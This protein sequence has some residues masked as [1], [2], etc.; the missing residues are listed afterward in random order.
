MERFL[1]LVRR[2]SGIV[3]LFST[4]NESLKNAA[5]WSDLQPYAIAEKRLESVD[6]KTYERNQLL[7]EAW[8]SLAS[9]RSLGDKTLA[10]CLIIILETLPDQSLE[11]AE[12]SLLAISDH[13]RE[14]K[15]TAAHPRAFKGTKIRPPKDAVDWHNLQTML[16]TIRGTNYLLEKLESHRSQAL[17]RLGKAGYSE[18]IVGRLRTADNLHS[19]YRLAHFPNF[20]AEPP[21][22]LPAEFERTV[23]AQLQGTDWASV[24]ALSETYRGMHIDT[25][26]N[27]SAAFA[28]LASYKPKNGIIA[29]S[30]LLAARPPEQRLLLIVLFI[31]TRSLSLKT[32]DL[33][34]YISEIDKLTSEAGGLVTSLSTLLN[35]IRRGHDPEYVLDG[36]RIEAALG[37]QLDLGTITNSCKTFDRELALKLDRELLSKVTRPWFNA[38]NVWRYCGECPDL[39]TI[40]PGILS[41]NIIPDVAIE[42]IYLLHYYR[43]DDSDPPKVQ[44]QKRRLLAKFAPQLTNLLSSLPVD[45]QARC[46]AEIKDF[47]QFPESSQCVEKNMASFLQFLQRICA[48]PFSPTLDL[49]CT[50]IGLIEN[51]GIDVLLKASD[52]CLLTLESQGKNGSMQALT[53]WGLSTLTE[54][55][56]QFIGH[57]FEK[58]TT[59]LCKTARV[60][61]T[62]SSAQ[63][64][65]ALQTIK[66]HPLMQDLS[67]F[68]LDAIYD[69]VV[70]Y[71]S[72]TVSSP[73]SARVCAYMMGQQTLTAEQLKRATEVVLRRLD[74]TRLDM[75]RSI[76]FSQ[77][78]TAVPR[79]LADEK[80]IHAVQL[81]NRS[82]YNRRAFKNFLK[83]HWNGQNTYRQDHPLSQRWLSKHPKLDIDL[84]SRGIT[85]TEAV[86]GLGEV[87][88]SVEQDPFEALKLGTYAN[89]CLG[90]NGMCNDS[91]L[92]IVL[93]I[94]KRVIY[95]RDSKGRVIG[96][97]LLAWNEVD[98]LVC[99]QVYPIKVDRALKQVFRK[100][101]ETLAKALGTTV[102]QEN[103]NE[104]S[105]PEI[106]FI[107]SKYWWDDGS[108]DPSDLDENE[109]RAG[110]EGQDLQASLTKE[111]QKN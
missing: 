101:D 84:F 29:W 15:P 67:H 85:A 95:A 19:V 9:V 102:Y 54:A 39:N 68:D 41:S 35:A 64:A 75:W 94:N 6:K 49:V 59:K 5:P 11:D 4:V 20:A 21:L 34:Y 27:F 66:E 44:A 89:T 100:Y 86:A 74:E 97:Q 81:F 1:G 91:S 70:P 57:T 51:L 38:V 13:E 48:P 42:Y 60:L 109:Q 73:F 47:F 93:D 96:R 43:Y 8:N 61:S 77:L 24:A 18:A 63:M 83:A 36:F 3:A 90:I 30:R 28:R 10:D 33:A 26:I 69:L 16:S 7:L 58:H 37:H 99:F 82:T 110:H 17:I 105:A 76:I 65:C 40:L 55:Q 25:D 103:T 14:V 53:R 88:L 106:C 79:Q 52:R 107:L 80:T 108:W 23:L 2:S 32:D 71:I 104:T 12:P 50:A 46:I 45:Y 111:E 78:K 87:T 56:P 31:T 98:Q 22:K 62:L 92:A 72:Q